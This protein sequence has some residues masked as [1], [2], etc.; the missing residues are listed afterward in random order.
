MTPFF[1]IKVKF[2]V[3]IMALPI[4]STLDFPKDKI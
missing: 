4:F 1:E 2:L 3:T